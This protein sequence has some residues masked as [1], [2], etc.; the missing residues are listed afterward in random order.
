MSDLLELWVKTH[1]QFWVIIHHSVH[2]FGSDWIKPIHSE[3]V[4][5]TGVWSDDGGGEPAAVDQT[6]VVANCIYSTQICTHLAFTRADGRQFQTDPFACLSVLPFQNFRHRHASVTWHAV[7]KNVS[8][9]YST[10]WQFRGMS[11]DGFGGG[12]LFDYRDSVTVFWFVDSSLEIRDI[13]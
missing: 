5:C 13:F 2:F 1:R 6:P 11:H 7:S 3:I 4:S 8:I 10:T 12:C 9:W